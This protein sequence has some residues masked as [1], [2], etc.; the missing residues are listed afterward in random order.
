MQNI[1][2]NY[3]YD[4]F[5]TWLRTEKNDDW[6][7][8][9]LEFSYALNSN[10]GISSWWFIEFYPFFLN[11]CRTQEDKNDRIGWMIGQI[12]IKVSTNIVI[13]KLI[14]AK[15]ALIVHCA[16][17]RLFTFHF[18]K[19]YIKYQHNLYLFYDTSNKIQQK[20]FNS[21]PPTSV[22]FNKE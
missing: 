8:M 3:S 7:V 4:A 19:A 11:K 1:A 6:N 14:R 2:L 9:V 18:K 21:F 5:L 20:M 15:R 17:P 12:E 13:S 10:H 22:F 16:C